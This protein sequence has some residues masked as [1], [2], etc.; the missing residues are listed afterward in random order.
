MRIDFHTLWDH[1][2]DPDKELDCNNRASQAFL[3]FR[4][5]KRVGPLLD[6]IFLRV[7]CQD[8]FKRFRKCN[9]NQT[10]TYFE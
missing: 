1:K 4:S 2:G 3:C 10:I 7:K 9:R 8:F 5:G 6:T